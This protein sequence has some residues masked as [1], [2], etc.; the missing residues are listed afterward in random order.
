VKV[1]VEV[2]ADGGVRS[3][4]LQ[5]M[6]VFQQWALASHAL[7]LFFAFALQRKKRRHTRYERRILIVM[8]SISSSA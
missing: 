6:G 4:E 8:A 5:I 2:M 1:V 7:D 3:G